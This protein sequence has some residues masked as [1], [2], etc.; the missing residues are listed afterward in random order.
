MV[1]PDCASLFTLLCQHLHLQVE[2]CIPFSCYWGKEVLAQ[3]CSE[4]HCITHHLQLS[5]VEARISR[6][7]DQLFPHG[8]SPAHPFA[9]WCSEKAI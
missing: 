9:D 7:P 1:V 8:A 5:T 3:V 2:A 6:R 4:A